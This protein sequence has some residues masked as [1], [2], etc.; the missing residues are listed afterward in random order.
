MLKK[1]FLILFTTLFYV[2]FCFATA[3]NTQITPGI[4]CSES[5]PNFGGYAYPSHVA[6]CIRNVSESEKSQIAQAYGNIKKSE[7]P[8]YEFDHLIPLCAGGSNDIRNIWPQPIQEAHGKDILENDICTQ[9]RSGQMNQQQA[10]AK[11]NQW[12]IAHQ[13]KP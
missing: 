10:L 5:D 11:V 9:L 4:L 7:W 1:L 8:N 6:K 3:P 12:I 13:F 2:N